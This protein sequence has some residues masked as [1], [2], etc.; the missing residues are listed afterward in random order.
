VKIRTLVIVSIVAL[1]FIFSGDLVGQNS[2]SINLKAKSR[3]NWFAKD[4]KVSSEQV[5]MQDLLKGPENDWLVYHGDYGANHYSPL[6]EITSKNVGTLVPKWVYKIND[7]AYLRSSP[8]VQNGIMYVTSANEVHALDART[9]QWLWIWQAYDKRS[10]GINRGVAIYGDKLL[11]STLD[12]RLVALNKETGNLLWSNHYAKTTDNY[13]STMTPLVIKGDMVVVGVA[14]SNDYAR[15]FVAAFS[16]TDGKELWRFWTLPADGPLLGA[17]TW[18]TG[19]YDPVADVI[20]WAVGTVPDRQ[21][22]D[23]QIYDTPNSFHDSIVALEAKTGKLKWQVRLARHLPIDWDP[24]EPLV[25]LDSGKQKLILLANRS[26]MYYVIDRE[27]GNIILEKPFIDK[28]NWDETKGVICPSVR[29]ATNWMPPSYNPIT[30]LLYVMTLEGCVDESNSYYVKAI[31]PLTGNEKW[32][33]A[34]RG[35]NISTPGILSTAGNVVFSSEGSGHVVALDAMTGNKLWDFNTAWPIF[36]APMSYA[37]D[38]SQYVAI[39]AGS[40]VINFS[41]FKAQ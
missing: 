32:R 20:Y 31:E 25:L 10:T 16:I 35:V 7:G 27:N 21:R 22:G 34:S 38:G 17:P 9:G 8:V 3:K 24:N 6:T 23:R 28:L 30:K 5:T 29:G 39:V 37:V 18:L 33:Y 19:S 1:F 15:G 4:I 26:G 14:N 2:D 11:F 12:C 40:D 13:F 36:A 41:L